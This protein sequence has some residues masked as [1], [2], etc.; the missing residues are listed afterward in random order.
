MPGVYLP[1]ALINAVANAGGKGT[2]D[3]GGQ[4]VAL[5]PTGQMTPDGSAQVHY[6]VLLAGKLLSAYTSNNYNIGS[7]R[8]KGTNAKECLAWIY[9]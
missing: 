6:P 4:Y 3:R 2:G 5:L 7:G 1:K 9:G 8:N